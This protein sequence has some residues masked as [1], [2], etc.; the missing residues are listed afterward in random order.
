MGNGS[1]ENSLH[2]RLTEEQQTAFH[3]VL[4]IAVYK[5]LHRQ[6]KITDMQLNELIQW[7]EK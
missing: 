2:I 3:K 6:K 4:K 7:Q 5:E 1:A